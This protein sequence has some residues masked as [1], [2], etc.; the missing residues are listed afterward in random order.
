MSGKEVFGETHLLSEGGCFCNASTPLQRNL[1]SGRACFMEI[2]QHW[3]APRK[4]LR[5]IQPCRRWR[6]GA[7]RRTGTRW[8]R[9]CRVGSVDFR[10][11]E[12]KKLRGLRQRIV[13]RRWSADLDIWGSLPSTSPERGHRKTR[14]AWPKSIAIHKKDSSARA[15]RLG[16]APYA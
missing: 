15:P 11:A 10:K 7:S 16:T 13:L 2:V 1:H 6:P 5:R 9:S 8:H 4:I 3:E 12:A 14:A